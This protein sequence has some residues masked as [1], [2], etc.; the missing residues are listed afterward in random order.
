[1]YPLNDFASGQYWIRIGQA[2]TNTWAYSGAFS[3][4]GNGTA[5]PVCKYIIVKLY[6]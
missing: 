4:V 2:S 1:M 3:F 5:S 6:G